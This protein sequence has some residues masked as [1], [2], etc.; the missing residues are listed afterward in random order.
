MDKLNTKEIPNPYDFN[1]KELKYFIDEIKD[2]IKDKKNIV[3]QYYASILISYPL[4][5]IAF[6]YVASNIY[7]NI[8]QKKIDIKLLIKNIVIFFILYGL[9]NL[10]RNYKDYLEVKYIPLLIK[11]I[12]ENIFNNILFRLKKQDA[13]IKIGDIIARFITIPT[14]VKDIITDIS[15]LLL[16]KLFKVILVVCI[17]LYVNFKIGLINLITILIIGIVLYYRNNNCFKYHF[18]NNENFNNV[19]Q[20]LQNK[21]YN[22][23]NIIISNNVNQE[24]EENKQREQVVYNTYSESK[25]CIWVTNNIIS[26][27]LGI[28]VLFVLY[29][30]VTKLINKDIKPKHAITSLVLISYFVPNTLTIINMIPYTI[31]N[32]ANLIESGDFINFITNFTKINGGKHNINGDIV[33]KKLNFKY[34]DSKNY[35]FRNLDITI[36]KNTSI[37]IIGKSGSGKSTL[38]KLLCGFFTTKK[39]EITVNNR[40]LNDIDVENLRSQ[41]GLMSQNIR[42]FED[43][44]LNNI[45]YSNA[46]ITEQ[47][48]Y[49][50]IQK[51]EIKVYDTIKNDLNTKIKPNETNISGGQKQFA[52]LMRVVLS[53]KKVLIL[54]E[55]TS[56][57]DDYHFQVIKKILDDLK[58]RKTII[59]ISHDNR[60]HYNDFDNTYKLRNQ[61][62]VKV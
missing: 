9:A 20:I 49:N 17:S 60:F 6:S 28:N 39:G 30:V 31:N 3:Y 7:T 24:I 25:K 1:S 37:M 27:I 55:P 52:I 43:S 48:I 14:S 32:Y 18:M 5:L 51:Y 53:N 38:M 34:G 57:L 2:F 11:H 22:I 15:V 40:D 41:L 8:S 36:K 16:P 61:I 19:N 12:R 21:L 35:V 58:G 54:D 42:M 50:F 26:I 59:V 45:M 13:S 47:D 10:T 4:E 46:N 29:V 62:L 33:I 23:F 44:I 56:A